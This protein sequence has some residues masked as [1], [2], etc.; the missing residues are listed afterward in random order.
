[1]GGNDDEISCYLGR[2]LTDLIER[3][4]G[5][6]VNGGVA[7]FLACCH[8]LQM[9]VHFAAHFRLRGDEGR[10]EGGCDRI[11]K[12]VHAHEMNA[13]TGSLSD[14]FRPLDRVK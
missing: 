8:L 6:D 2:E 1:M 13:R 11:T 10:R 4:A 12:I 5:P 9:R 7:Q 3:P 14:E